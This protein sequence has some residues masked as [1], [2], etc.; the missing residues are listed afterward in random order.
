MHSTTPSKPVTGRMWVGIIAVTFGSIAT[1]LTFVFTRMSPTDA[2]AW[3]M[4]LQNAVNTVRLFEVAALAFTAYQ[5][6]ASR[7]ERRDAEA[8]AVRRARKDANYQAWQVINS[9]QGKG[10]SGGRIDALAD[11][12]RNDVSL[13][14][15]NLDGAWL[16][17]IDLRNASLPMASFEKCNLQGACFDG[18]RLDGANLRHATLTAASFAGASLRGVDLTGARLSATNL[19][20]A[21]LT[22]AHGW[23]EVS[24]FAHANVEGLRAAPRG[25]LE[26]ARMG[27]A[28][29]TARD[30]LL[31]HP[32]QSREFRV[33]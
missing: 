25:F 3:T 6:L 23:R 20:G 12:V 18:A 13:A 9:A 16:E 10:G 29:D 17:S 26:W 24:T 11:L 2:A 30:G 33:L 4:W 28:M 14:G 1:V 8:E 32:E 15:I 7:A 21:D 5:V 27:G 31:L 22:D 19:A